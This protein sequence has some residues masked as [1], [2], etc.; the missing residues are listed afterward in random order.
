MITMRIRELDT[1][2]R[3]DVMQFINFQF[4]LYAHCKYWSPPLV[5]S[6]KLVMDRQR[7][8]FYK[9]SEAAFFVAESAGDT[10]ARVA[11]LEN[12]RYNEF[13]QSRAAFFYY[14]D[15][16]D[17]ANAAMTVLEAAVQWARQRGLNRLFGPK[18]FMRSDAYGVL[19]EGFEYE[20]ALGMP[21]NYDYYPRLVEAAG[22]E[23]LVDYLSGYVTRGQQLPDRITR[24]VDKIKQRYGFE[25]RN[26]RN[27]RELQRLAPQI[28]RINNE[29]F[30]D[31]WGYYP[32]DAGETQMISKQMLAIAD[33]QFI[34]V[35]A[36]GDE[37]AGF[38]F[39]F[40]DISKAL[41]ETRGR[42]WPLGWIKILRAF[43]TTQKLSGNGVGLLPQYQ[44]MGASALLYA[45]VFNTLIASRATHCDIA[46]AM[47]TNE[48]SLGDMNLLGVNWYKRHR[49]YQYVLPDSE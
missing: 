42:L 7:H 25:V 35:V 23:K 20:A 2:N 37:I 43:Q 4:D 1:H 10:L 28:Q 24:L 32:I 26:F 12:R 16:V 36:K 17:D 47:E 49:V 27:K 29:A 18:G 39:I 11:V 22:F 31:V 6:M 13:N 38:L 5:S 30:T 46:Q 45:E 48:K 8:P 19:V 41:R 34:K 33:P 21:Y 14:F 44:G 40:P 15:A 3:R 9:H